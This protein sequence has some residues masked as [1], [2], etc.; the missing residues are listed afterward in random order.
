MV[1]L[2][3]VTLHMRLRLSRRPHRLIS[4]QS[5]VQ[6]DRLNGGIYM[7]AS[8]PY[9]AYACRPSRYSWTNRPA[10]CLCV[11]SAVYV[12]IHRQ[13]LSHALRHLNTHRHRMQ[14]LHDVNTHC[15]ASEPAAPAPIGIYAPGHIGSYTSWLS[16]CHPSP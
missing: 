13:H 16:I 5:M 1:A 6:S 15:S 3:C 7:H 8:L 11:V 4:H 9:L 12:Y 10:V 14:H 2:V